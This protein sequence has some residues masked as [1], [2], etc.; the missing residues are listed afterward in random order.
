M[1]IRPVAASRLLAILQGWPQ[2]VADARRGTPP[3]VTANRPPAARPHTET[4]L[5]PS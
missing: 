2:P 4:L 1:A 5:V 3:V